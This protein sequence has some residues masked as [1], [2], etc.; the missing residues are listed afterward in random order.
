MVIE[1]K[2]DSANSFMNGVAM[3]IIFEDPEKGIKGQ[4]FF[5]DKAGNIVGDIKNRESGE[6]QTKVLMDSTSN[7]IN[8]NQNQ[9]EQKRFTV[10]LDPGHGGKDPGGILN[11]HM[12]EKN[13]N[14][15]TAKTIGATL[16]NED[17]Q[18]RFT[19]ETDQFV[20]LRQRTDMAKEI[21]ADFLISIHNIPMIEVPKK[22]IIITYAKNNTQS[23]A[24]ADILIKEMMTVS[25]ESVIRLEHNYW[26]LQT[27][28]IPSIMI[29]PCFSTK[30][31]D[32][33][34]FKDLGIGGILTKALISTIHSYLRSS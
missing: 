29:E 4:G 26:V 23:K 30:R 20:G 11:A 3:V 5:I 8:T 16:R 17:F 9:K 14:L 32:A 21:G 25:S 27:L 19:R 22:D 1:P 2:F 34:P 12:M 31:Q 33:A 18:V 24:F 7:L 28:P 10:L 13:W 15:E 6:K